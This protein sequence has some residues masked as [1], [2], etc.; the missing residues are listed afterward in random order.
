MIEDN[1]QPDYNSVILTSDA[2]SDLERRLIAL[3]KLIWKLQGKRKKIVAL[4]D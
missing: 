2:L 3:L 1:L 4:V